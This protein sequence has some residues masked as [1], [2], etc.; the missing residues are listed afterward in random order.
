MPFGAFSLPS[1]SD[2]TNDILFDLTNSDGVPVSESVEIQTDFIGD[3]AGAE[4]A[5]VIFSLKLLGALT[6]GASITGQ[7]I[8]VPSVG[9]ISGVGGLLFDPGAG[10]LTQVGYNLN[11][12][13]LQL[14]VNTTL[15]PH[16]I[17]GNELL[18]DASGFPAGGVALDSSFNN[19]L[20][21]T[22]SGAQLALRGAGVNYMVMNST[23]LSFN[24]GTP[25]AMPHI[26]AA[27]TNNAT[28]GTAG[29]IDTFTGTVYA[30][31]SSIIRGDINQLAIKINAIDAALRAAPGVNLVQT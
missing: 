4:T 29:V 14:N 8:K 23:G 9:A 22:L 17:Y 21:F 10:A 27:L 28:G 5:G 18:L 7:G 2:V 3:V 16:L 30:T 15:H 11:Q 26:G 12:P 13:A 1:E 31:D 24:N 20:L 25:V 19:G 6:W